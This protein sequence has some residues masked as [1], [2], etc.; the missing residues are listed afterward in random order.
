MRAL[1]LSPHTLTGSKGAPGTRTPAR[2]EQRGAA[3]PANSRLFA[4][5]R[6][7]WR[8]RESNPRPQ[9]RGGSVYERS[10]LSGSRP[11]V[12]V[13]AGFVGTSLLKC[14]RVG[15][16]DPSRVKPT[17]EAGPSVAGE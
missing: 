9:S 5:A 7:K 12:A 8:R 11:D 16:G 6:T 14:P 3:Y 10:R 4:A 2:P 1:L 13:P 15:E 17:S